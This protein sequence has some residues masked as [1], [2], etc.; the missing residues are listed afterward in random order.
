MTSNKALKWKAISPK[1][2]ENIYGYGNVDEEYLDGY[3]IV[4]DDPEDPDVPWVIASTKEGIPGTPAKMI[5]QEI[6]DEHNRLIDFK[7]ETNFLQSKKSLYLLSD[8]DRYM[9]ASVIA[10]DPKT[11][12]S[13]YS[14]H[15]GFMPSHLDEVREADD[16]LLI[17]EDM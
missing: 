1:E 2:Y 8:E 17:E 4:S 6:V 3:Y 5:A 16:V 9:K 13:L 15:F 12:I 11:A 10:S 7:N 14:N